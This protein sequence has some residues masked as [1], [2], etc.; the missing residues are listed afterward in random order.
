M[1]WCHIGEITTGP[2]TGIGTTTQNK[3]QKRCR[4]TNTR[5]TRTRPLLLLCHYD[6]S[7]HGSVYKHLSGV[8]FRNALILH[9]KIYPSS[10]RFPFGPDGGRDKTQRYRHG[11]P[12]VNER[13]PLNFH[14]QGSGHVNDVPIH[15]TFQFGECEMRKR[16][17]WIGDVMSMAHRTCWPQ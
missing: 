9:S 7:K 3:P 8:A 14:N 17:M 15:G 11:I 16:R 6:T 4:F 1:R 5:T 12:A 10:Y 2:V 13:I